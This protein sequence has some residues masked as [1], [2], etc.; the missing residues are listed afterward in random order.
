MSNT[1]HKDLMIK[2][3]TLNYPVK[4]LKR[5]RHFNRGIIM[6]NGESYFLSDKSQSIPLYSGLVNMLML[7]F[8]CGES[9]SREAVASFLN[10]KNKH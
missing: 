10:I 7:V 1:Q 8:G 9:E 5:G 3:L 4:R 6:D 2:F